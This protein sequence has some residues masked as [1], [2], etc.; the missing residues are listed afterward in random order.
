MKEESRGSSGSAGR[1]RLRDSLIV[2]E[3]ALAFVLLVGSGLMMR[4]FFRLM[5]V[6]TGFDATNI[7]TMRLPTT[8]EQFPDPEQVESDICSEIRTAVAAVPGVRETAYSCAPPMQGTL[9]RDADAAGQQADGGSREP[10]RRLLQGGQP[11]LF[12][13]ARHQDDQRAS[14]V[15]H[16]TRGM[17]RAR[18]CMN[19]RLAKR[20]F[21]KEDPIGQRLLIQEI[22][23]GKTELGA[24]IVVGSRGRHR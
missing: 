24:D 11:V 1:R 2:V 12:L 8:I 20:Y 5:T 3:I 17:R 4:S 21:D 18:W 10:V 19:E 15:R 6:D 14:A 22:M 16:A 7:L 13:H 23:P 9:L